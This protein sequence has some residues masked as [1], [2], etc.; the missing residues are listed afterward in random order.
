[1]ID[2]RNI[3]YA[4]GINKSDELRDAIIS[5]QYYLSGAVSQNLYT[6]FVTHSKPLL[7][8]LEDIE[9]QLSDNI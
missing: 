3:N 9:Y 1:M 6:A 7:N 5:L 8:V 2:T 4:D